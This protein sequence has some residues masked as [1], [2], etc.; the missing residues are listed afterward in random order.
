[1]PSPPTF[2]RAVNEF[3]TDKLPEKIHEA[4]VKKYCGQK[5]AGHIRR[6]STAIESREKPVKATK[7]SPKPKGTRGRPRKGDTS[8]PKPRKRVELQAERSLEENLNELPTVC[9][10]GIKKNSKGYKTTWTGYKLHLDCVD[11]D[12]PISAILRASEKIKRHSCSITAIS[13][14]RRKRWV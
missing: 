7:A 4:I 11:G 13:L 5:L 3:S 1:M 8:V 2:S 14:R 10:V 6:D 12:I 9:N